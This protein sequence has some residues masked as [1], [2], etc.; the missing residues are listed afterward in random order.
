L[1]ELEIQCASSLPVNITGLY[2]VEEKKK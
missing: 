1:K 2:D